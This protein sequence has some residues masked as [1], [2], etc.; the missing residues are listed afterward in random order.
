[1]CM[2]GISVVESRQCAGRSFLREIE[3][4]LGRKTE[5]SRGAQGD[6][7]RQGEKV[8]EIRLAAQGAEG[9]ET[10]DKNKTLPR[11]FILC[12]A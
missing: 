10:K 2:R 12:N 3:V 9:L 11:H 1:M 4:L 8:K 7:C 6:G 5:E